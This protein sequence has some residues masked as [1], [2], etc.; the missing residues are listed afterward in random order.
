[1]LRAPES[2]SWGTLQ[3]L[4]CEKLPT[5]Q[6]ITLHLGY[7]APQT[8][9]NIMEY[10]TRLDFKSPPKCETNPSLIVKM[11]CHCQIETHTRT[12]TW[13]KE[14]PLWYQSIYPGLLSQDG[15]ILLLGSCCDRTTAPVL[16]FSQCQCYEPLPNPHALASI[17]GRSL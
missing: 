13:R 2:E 9:F 16:S 6:H 8:L 15:P 1:M 14:P 5:S 11:T 12:T 10:E 3:L 17:C 4:H 7:E